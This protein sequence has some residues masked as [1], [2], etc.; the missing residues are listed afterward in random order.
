MAAELRINNV[1]A[2]G[3]GDNVLVGWTGIDHP[4]PRDWIGIWERGV[5]DASQFQTTDGAGPGT[6]AVVFKTTDGAGAGN[7]FL[8]LPAAILPGSYEVRLY[9]CGGYSLLAQIPM[10]VVSPIVAAPGPPA[11]VPQPSALPALGIDTS[12]LMK[13][14]LVM[15]AGALVLLQLFRGRR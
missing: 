3:P 4:D 8:P 12:A 6:K 15:L 5:Q 13:N 10:Q 7:M 11:A 9:C 14:P 1:G 2:I